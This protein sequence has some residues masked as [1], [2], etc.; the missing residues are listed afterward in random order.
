MVCKKKHLGKLYFFGLNLY[1]SGPSP[2]PSLPYLPVT[3]VVHEIYILNG[4]TQANLYCTGLGI[5]AHFVCTRVW[6]Y[7]IKYC[8]VHA[9]I[10]ILLSPVF[11]PQNNMYQFEMQLKYKI[12]L[13][14]IQFQ[15]TPFTGWRLDKLYNCWRTTTTE[16]LDLL[17]CLLLPTGNFSIGRIKC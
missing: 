11:M 4:C 13:G 5:Y 9:R 16:V 8:S 14:L 10:L 12:A 3:A 7:T 2:Y 17:L 15:N 1:P 6:K